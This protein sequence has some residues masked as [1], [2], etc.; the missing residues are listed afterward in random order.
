MKMYFSD[1]VPLTV[2]ADVFSDSNG[3]D[4]ANVWAGHWRRRWRHRRRGW[5]QWCTPQ[6]RC[7]RAPA[8]GT[9]S[10][11]KPGRT[12]AFLCTRHES[13]LMTKRNSTHAQSQ[14]S[15]FHVRKAVMVFRMCCSCCEKALLQQQCCL[16]EGAY[17]HETSC[18]DGPSRGTAISILSALL[19]HYTRVFCHRCVLTV[20]AF[21]ASSLHLSKILSSSYCQCLSSKATLI[22]AS[23]W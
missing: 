6:H 8:D 3:T 19:F 22:N 21:S 14:A 10:M 9:P 12:G 7:A 23:Q 4:R 13:W 1:C 2:N 20:G 17:D 16:H 18:H 11:A 5:L 15:T